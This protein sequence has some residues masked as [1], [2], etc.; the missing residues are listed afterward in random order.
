MEHRELLL[1]ISAPEL[2]VGYLILFWSIL[3]RNLQV[4]RFYVIFKTLFAYQYID[5]TD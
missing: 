2:L 3:K 1:I 4:T 5:D